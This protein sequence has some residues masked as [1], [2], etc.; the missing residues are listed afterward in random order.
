MYVL[1]SDVE[2]ISAYVIAQL[3]KRGLTLT[4]SARKRMIGLALSTW[5]A[6]GLRAMRE[7]VEWEITLLPAFKSASD[8]YIDV[9]DKARG[10]IP[11]RVGVEQYARKI[12]C[13]LKSDDFSYYMKI[14]KSYDVSGIKRRLHSIMTGEE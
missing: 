4:E 11:R 7:V 12:G 13:E 6:D 1:Q 5:R 14:P 3:D 2:G 10:T 9:W 8:R